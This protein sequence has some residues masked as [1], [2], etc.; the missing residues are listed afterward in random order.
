MTVAVSEESKK[1]ADALY[2]E[3]DRQAAELVAKR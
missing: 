2:L 3:M 1:V